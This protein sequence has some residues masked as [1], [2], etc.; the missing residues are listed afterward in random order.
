MEAKLLKFEQPDGRVDYVVAETKCM[1][2]IL[3]G[4]LI[5]GRYIIFIYNAL[6]NNGDGGIEFSYDIPVKNKDDFQLLNDDEL[7]EVW[8]KFRGLFCGKLESCLL[9]RDQVINVNKILTEIESDIKTKAEETISSRKRI[10]K[11]ARKETDE[12]N[13]EFIN[14]D[15]DSN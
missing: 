9:E 11:K 3:E 8:H 2:E 13:K 4:D 7:K 12:K 15:H 1:V 14:N 10:N 6:D 5:P